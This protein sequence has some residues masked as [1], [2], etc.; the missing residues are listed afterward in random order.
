MKQLTLMR[1]GRAEPKDPRLSDFDRPLHRRG[2]LE[3]TTMG[4]RA[5]EIDRVPDLIIAS[6]AVRTRQTAEAFARAIELP[7]RKVLKE[8][9]LYLAE[10]DEIIEV[11]RGTGIRVAHLMLVG[12]NPGLSACANRLAATGGPGEFDTGALCTIDL[13]IEKWT[14]ARF[15]IGRNPQYDTPKRFFD[16]W[17]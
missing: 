11:I 2:L 3:A 6:S 5:R 9:E 16:L 1:H 7:A 4:E 14:D 15:G 10:P 12:H 8:D 13:P 17:S